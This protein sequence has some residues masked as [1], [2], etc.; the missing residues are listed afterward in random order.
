M[1]ESDFDRNDDSLGDKALYT[2]SVKIDA[3][4]SS[5]YK[6]SVVMPSTGPRS[7]KDYVDCMWFR[8]A[9][10]GKVLAA[11]S[12]GSNGLSRDFSL[13]EDTGLEPSFAAR[14]PSGKTVVPAI[15]AKKGG[16]WEGA[17]FKVK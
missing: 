1:Y 17:E 16:T 7:A 6:L 9:S 12:F 10:N 14:I 11:E 2:P 8:D 13:R 3:A 15:H 5:S 4:G